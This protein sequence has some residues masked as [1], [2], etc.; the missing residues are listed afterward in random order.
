MKS[1]FSQSL[2]KEKDLGLQMTLEAQE[3]E[4]Q[5]IA[6]D[7]HDGV[8]QD[9][10]SMKFII[11]DLPDTQE[12]SNIL[13]RLD[14]TANEVRNISHQMMPFALKELGLIPA[15]KDLLE[16]LLIPNNIKYEFEKIG[17]FDKRLPEK[18]EVSLYRIL[19]ELINNVI[20]HSKADA[21]T[22]TIS[23][24][25]GNLLLLFEDNGKGLG[26]G[27]R[28]VGLGMTSLDSRVKMLKGKIEFES[29]NAG[30]TAIINIPLI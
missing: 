10:I 29:E 25:K 11:R 8:V 15:T 7:L 26:Q 9:I 24:R 18:I 30:T 22:V 28:N 4:R 21:V 3:Q 1:L 20:K 17:D 16:R 12:K 2:A 23:N 14:K 27:V 13:K 6:K 5:R 19:Q